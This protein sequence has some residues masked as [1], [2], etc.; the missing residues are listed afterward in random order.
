MKVCRNWK[1]SIVFVTIKC[2]SIV[3]TKYQNKNFKIRDNSDLKHFKRGMSK[4]KLRKMKKYK[5][6]KKKTN[7]GSDGPN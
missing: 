1:R 4:R 3:F 7:C 5:N 2:F 6:M